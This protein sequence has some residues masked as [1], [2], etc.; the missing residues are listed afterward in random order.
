LTHAVLC[1]FIWE[2]LYEV[3][4][5]CALFEDDDNDDEKSDEIKWSEWW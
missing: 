3:L 4:R 1:I 2:S 5:A